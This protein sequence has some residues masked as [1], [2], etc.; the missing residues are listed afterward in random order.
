MLQLLR[1]RPQ[2]CPD[3][4]AHP[5]GG[6]GSGR[7]QQDRPG[8]RAARSRGPESRRASDGCEDSNCR[9]LLPVPFREKPLGARC[10]SLA[11]GACARGLI[12]PSLVRLLPGAARP[13]TGLLLTSPLP[14]L[15]WVDPG[16]QQRPQSP[17]DLR[18]PRGEVIAKHRDACAGRRPLRRWGT[19]ASAP[20]ASGVTPALPS[21]CA[22]RP[23]EPPGTARA[24]VFRRSHSLLPNEPRGL[25]SAR[26]SSHCP[27]TRQPQPSPNQNKIRS[28]SSY[29][30]TAALAALRIAITPC[31][32]KP[33]EQR[34]IKV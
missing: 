31:S 16:Q 5:R 29:S 18:L 13:R 21:P 2:C 17:A 26:S 12:A 22:V 30:E 7:G 28:H 25:T 8:G 32:R 10:E 33:Q 1:R 3:A 4:R 23:A 19:D 6:Q 14:L 27:S 15:S 20:R 9:K 24:L 34:G 11:Q